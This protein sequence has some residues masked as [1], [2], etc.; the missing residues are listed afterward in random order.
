[1]IKHTYYTITLGKFIEAA[2][3]GDYKDIY[4]EFIFKIKNAE[5][6]YILNLTKNIATIQY[7]YNMLLLIVEWQKL[8]KI[9]GYKSDDEE[10]VW[11]ILTSIVPARKTDTHEVLI[12]RGGK[13]IEKKIALEKELSGISTVI[14]GKKN[15]DHDFFNRLIASVSIYHQFQ[16]NRDTTLLC[17][18]VEY[19]TIMKEQQEY[20]DKDLKK[21]K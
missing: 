9:A 20:A 2:S 8:I 17:E 4:E 15:A 16:I 6:D 5:Q 19:Y 18:F 3:K 7:K 12:A 21:Q 14:S 1:M 11:K 13:L 10:V